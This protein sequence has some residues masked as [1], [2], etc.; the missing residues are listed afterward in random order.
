MF[1]AV[2][3]TCV[4]WP[5]LQRDFLLSLAAEGIYRPLWSDRI[6]DE[7]E[8]SEAQKLVERG[9]SA[10]DAQDRAAR[11]VERM[12]LAFDDSCVTGWER[13]EGSYGLP[14]PDDEHV[15]AA[16]EFANAGA[17]VTVNIK[18]FPRDRLPPSIGIQSPPE[19][20]QNTVEVNPT[21]AAV[22]IRTLASRSGRFGR[23]RS[24]AEI[25]DDLD[26]LYAM[27]DAA[28]LIRPLIS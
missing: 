7:L 5:S 2:L 8:Y 1:A 20:A 17:I 16:A 25:L 15:L 9:A 27:S 13:L 26:R 4:L 21:G 28:A 24:P 11:L 18:D 6:L 23:G 12:R 3:D 14:D 10:S 19:F 22:A